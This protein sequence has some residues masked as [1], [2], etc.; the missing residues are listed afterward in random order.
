[1]LKNGFKCN[2]FRIDGSSKSAIID[3]NDEY[4]IRSYKA[5]SG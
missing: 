5:P 2:L 3:I 4:Q 1:M